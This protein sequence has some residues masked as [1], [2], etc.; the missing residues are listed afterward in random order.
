MSGRF[1]GKIALVTG[2]SS[3]IGQATALAFAREGAKV[4]A[5]DVVTPA[6][7]EMVHA[8]WNAGGEALFVQTDVSKA[9]EVEALINKTVTIY[10]QLDC[11]YNNAGVLGSIAV[12]IHEYPEEIWDQVITINLKGIWLCMKYEI[13]Q[14]LAQGSG[15]I[16]NMS[17]IWG[18]VG[19]SGFSAYVSSKHG[20]V[21][22]TKSAALEYAQAGL[23]INAVNPGPIDTPMVENALAQDPAIG[24]RLLA[25]EPIGRLGTPDE[26]AEAVIWLCSDAAS[27]VTGHTMTID[28]GYVAQ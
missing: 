17:S 27:F 21:G 20:V 25:A 6:G 7:E 9:A 23:R 10:G 12:P 1:D 18:L 4:V 22:L 15:T 13:L 5:A 16:V 8:I 24:E 2:V 28:G 26:I 3:G 14:M 19:A 11:A